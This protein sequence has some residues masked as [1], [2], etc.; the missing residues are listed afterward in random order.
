MN[1]TYDKLRKHFNKPDTCCTSSEWYLKSIVSELTIQYLIFNDKNAKGEKL[2][3]DHQFPAWSCSNSFYDSIGE[4]LY[5]EEDDMKE[6]RDTQLFYSREYFRKL[7]KSIP[8]V[9]IERI[10]FCPCC[11]KFDDIFYTPLML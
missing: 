11:N 8:Y 5:D 3:E 10:C 6:Y 4:H 7:V 9:L 2:D 1:N